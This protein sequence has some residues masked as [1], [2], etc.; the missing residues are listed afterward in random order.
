M[1]GDGGILVPGLPFCVEIETQPIEGNG[2]IWPGDP[3]TEAGVMILEPDNAGR[4]QLSFTLEVAS[5]V[6]LWARVRAQ[7]HSN[8]SVFVGLDGLDANPSNAASWDIPI[9]P[10]LSWQRVLPRG[11]SGEEWK[12]EDTT[13]PGSLDAGLHQLVVA[14]REPS[15]ELDAFCVMPPG[16]RPSPRRIGV[17]EH[18]TIVDTT[19]FGVTGDGTTDDTAALQEAI[20]S[21]EDGQTLLL[22]AG[23][24][25][26]TDA[27][28]IR[29]S[30]VTI[31]GTIE[32]EERLSTI[33][34]DHPTRSP[35]G[36]TGGIVA[37][38]DDTGAFTPLLEDALPT[39][40]EVVVDASAEFSVG[41]L[42]V[43][44]SDPWGPDNPDLVNAG[45]EPSES[46]RFL[47][48]HARIM[49]RTVD[50]SQATLVLDRPFFERFTL[51]NNA[52]A[53]V[54]H[55]LE[56]I[57]VRSLRLEGTQRHLGDDDSEWTADERALNADINFIRMRRMASSFLYD[58]EILHFRDRGFLLNDTFGIQVF[59]NDIHDSTDFDGGG[60]GYGLLSE[61][62]QW[63]SV[64]SNKLW[65]VMRHSLSFTNGTVESS[66]TDNDMVRLPAAQEPAPDHQ[67]ACIDI[68]GEYSYA[69]LIARNRT[70]RGEYGVIIGGGFDSHG[71]DGPWI[72]V[73]DNTI[74][75]A[76]AGGLGTNDNS[77]DT[78][79][80]DNTLLNNDFGV[81][82]WKNSD[83]TYVWGNKIDGW[84][85]FGSGVLV[86]DSNETQILGNTFTGGANSIA[87]EFDDACNGYLVGDNDLGGGMVEHPGTGTVE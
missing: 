55:P 85:Q 5:E 79:F 2:R 76:F 72:V 73:R 70:V 13:W 40:R 56:N 25:R 17:P 27:L 45:V 86:E 38:G 84:Y 14:G 82:I 74:E 60:R 49:E 71:N 58:L 69:L 20:D 33:F 81:R 39:G 29:T 22:P 47:K 4:V 28:R 44:D 32:G 6:E 78:V 15:V 59:E 87:I 10:V 53:S 8:N 61:Q 63:L 18:S 83:R 51:A 26:T 75:E 43:V 23:R 3:T 35:N 31:A 57:V 68:H 30:N 7:T 24:Y 65:G 37:I 67:W 64:Y 34:F 62:S 50:G 46:F 66:M 48:V 52:R 41:D 16:E 1:S 21:L 9:T 80:Q 36:S 11:A 12:P 19:S 77:H 42:I 54:F